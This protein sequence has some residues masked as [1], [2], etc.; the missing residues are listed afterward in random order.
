MLARFSKLLLVAT[1][2]C[3]LGLHW[4]LLQSVAWV[5]MAVHFS[6][7]SPL[8]EALVKTFDGKHP[9]SLCKHI[10]K[11][12]STEKKTD[13]TLDLKKQEFPYAASMFIFT[14][15][16]LYWEVPEKASLAS[17]LTDAPPVP[18]P[19]ILSA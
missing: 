5:N 7:S 11:S 10:S 15:P 12:K 9:C 19:R 16:T 4:A 14:P 17:D 2:T 1:L 18:P 6:R 3:S 13:S 8:T